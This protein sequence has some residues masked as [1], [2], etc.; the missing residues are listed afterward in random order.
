MPSFITEGPS[1]VTHFVVPVGQNANR[2]LTA[3]GGV[4]ISP[5]FDPRTRQYEFFVLDQNNKVIAII[6]SILDSS[7]VIAAYNPHNRNLIA[8]YERSISLDF[9]H[10]LLAN[11]DNFLISCD[12]T[13]YLVIHW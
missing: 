2:V 1:Q 12:H 9:S 5:R 3:L 8:Q 13:G 10:Q 7:L 11:A 6:I 4:D